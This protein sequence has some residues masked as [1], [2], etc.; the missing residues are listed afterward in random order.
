MHRRAMFSLTDSQMGL[1]RPSH[2]QSLSNYALGTA[3][4]SISSMT[5]RHSSVHAAH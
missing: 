5:V 1:S 4:A 3:R 2:T